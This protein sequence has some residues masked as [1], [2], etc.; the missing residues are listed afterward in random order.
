MSELTEVDKIV[1]IYADLVEK[2]K[3]TLGSVPEK[4]R[5]YVDKELKGA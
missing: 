3:R 4:L 5:E 2:G 1:R